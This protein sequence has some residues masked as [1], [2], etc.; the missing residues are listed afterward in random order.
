[1]CRRTRLIDA[2]ATGP[3]PFASVSPTTF[4]F[5]PTLRGTPLTVTDRLPA[6][7]TRNSAFPFPSFTKTAWRKPPGCGV[8]L[9]TSFEP[10]RLMRTSVGLRGRRGPGAR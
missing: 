9:I 5:A 6:A 7:T 1:L 2:L 3:F 4:T 8:Q 10:R